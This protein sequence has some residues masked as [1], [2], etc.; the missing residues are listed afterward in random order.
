[1]AIYHQATIEKAND[2]L[3]RYGKQITVS[4]NRDKTY[5]LYVNSMLIWWCIP[6]ERLLQ[7][8]MA[9]FFYNIGFRMK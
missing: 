4:Q 2:Y 3:K 6:E 5:A 1:M 7:N 9:A 8:I